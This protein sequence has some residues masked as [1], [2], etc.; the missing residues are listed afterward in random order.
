MSPQQIYRPGAGHCGML[1]SRL[2]C[3]STACESAEQV[4]LCKM[5]SNMHMTGWWQALQ[6]TDG[7]RVIVLVIPR[8][9]CMMA[10]H[11]KQQ[12]TTSL[13]HGQQHAQEVSNDQEVN[14]TVMM[15]SRVLTSLVMK[16][17]S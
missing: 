5:A 3:R 17:T 9:Y 4:L 6:V 15:H 12:L 2:S 8:C 13:K 7:M 11:N 1:T 14:K 16:A 10:H